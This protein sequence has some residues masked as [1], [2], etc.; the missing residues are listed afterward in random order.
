MGK[1]TTPSNGPEEYRGLD[2]L[3]ELYRDGLTRPNRAE[4]DRGLAGVRERIASRSEHRW[5]L[6]RWSLAGAAF[7][8][9]TL[10]VALALPALRRPVAVPAPPALAYQIEGGSVLP[11]GYLREL[12]HSGIKLRF[13]DG[14]EL[15]L[16]PGARGRLRSVETEVAR[17]AIDHGSASF[18][19][20][21]TENRRWLI[22]V[23]PF[24][25]TVKGTV[26][27]A[28]WDPLSERFELRLRQGRLVVSGP[29]ATGDIDLA[30]G[31]RLVVNLAKA[32]TL[33]S[34]EPSDDGVGNMPAPDVVT[35]PAPQL[36]AAPSARPAPSVSSKPAPAIGVKGG[37][38][39]WA[40]DLAKGRWDRILEDA[41]R[42]G[43]AATLGK[44]S[45]E[46]LFV[47][48]D[49]AR[50]RRRPDVA[51][52]ALLAARRRFPDSPRTLDATFLLGRVEELHAGGRA[53]AIAWYDEYLARAPTGT[54]AAEALGRKMMLTGEGE[55]PVRAR[56]LADEYLRRF[57]NGSYA[58]SARA[59][60]A[61]PVPSAP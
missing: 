30:A 28:S 58:R 3:T 33:I 44:A 24:L 12:G 13:N 19:V 11:G 56:P 7:A 15:A 54:L 41:E 38:S 55:G 35:A 52:G 14:S 16:A 49:A 45:L 34:E 27:T 21:R 5:G 51:R 61:Q 31:H 2:I 10:V 20:K 25:V 40:E 8:L 43:V 26:F 29:A 1:M 36:P 47:L 57:P 18:Q 42:G 53:Q 48:A 37:G 4:L 23:G 6:A 39:R 17:V 59:L 46:D 50:Y 60:Q 9:A 22:D 32:E